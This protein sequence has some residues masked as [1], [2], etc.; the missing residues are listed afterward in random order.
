MASSISGLPCTNSQ[1]IDRQAHAWGS[2]HHGAVGRNGHMP[3]SNGQMMVMREKIG[4]AERE[5]TVTTQA[6]EREG[7]RDVVWR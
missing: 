3:L 6:R 7:G 1:S 5:V 2:V 4:V